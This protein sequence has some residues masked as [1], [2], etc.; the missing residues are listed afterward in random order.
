MKEL[1]LSGDSHFFITSVHNPGMH[2]H[3][4]GLWENEF[5]SLVGGGRELYYLSSLITPIIDN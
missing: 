1:P 4:E 2:N 3:L 5:K